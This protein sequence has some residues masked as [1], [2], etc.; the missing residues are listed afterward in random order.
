M[1]FSFADILPSFANARPRRFAKP[2][3]ETDFVGVSITKSERN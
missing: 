3:E 1:A 2:E